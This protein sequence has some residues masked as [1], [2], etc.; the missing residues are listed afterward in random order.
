MLT[1]QVKYACKPYQLTLDLGKST[2]LTMVIIEIT[3]TSAFAFWNLLSKKKKKREKRKNLIK[4][5]PG[6]KLSTLEKALHKLSITFK[7]SNV[8]KIGSMFCEMIACVVLCAASCCDQVGCQI[9]TYNITKTFY[10]VHLKS[11]GMK[12]FMIF[13]NVWLNLWCNVSP[14]VFRYIL[15]L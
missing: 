9:P 13:S 4:K 8:F 1:V 10:S 7:N 2:I 11:V 5:M 15:C 14:W 12:D 3:N 6:L